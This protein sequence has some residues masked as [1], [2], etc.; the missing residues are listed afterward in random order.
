MKFSYF[1]FLSCKPLRVHSYRKTACVEHRNLESL[2]SLRNI[3]SLNSP[4]RLLYRVLHINRSV[5]SIIFMH[6]S[7]RFSFCGCLFVITKFKPKK[8]KIR[9][10]SKS[11]KAN[12]RLKICLRHILLTTVYAEKFLVVLEFFLKKGERFVT[13]TLIKVIEEIFNNKKVIKEI[14]RAEKMQISGGNF[15]PFCLLVSKFEI[16]SI[17]AQIVLTIREVF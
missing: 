16:R 15:S 6:T 9:F 14:K 17:E 11:K 3:D 13:R 12:E 4:K 7:S 10:K 5:F 2:S 1:L 8:K